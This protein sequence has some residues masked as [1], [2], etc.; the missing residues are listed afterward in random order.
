MDGM[1]IINAWLFMLN[2]LDTFLCV[3]MIN[4]VVL[5]VQKA[6]GELPHFV[7]SIRPVYMEVGDPR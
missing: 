7:P 1:V 3:V 6:T 4:Y 2:Y 5:V